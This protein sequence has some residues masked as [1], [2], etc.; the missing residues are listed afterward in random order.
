MN[1]SFY[2]NNIRCDI[3]HSFNYNNNTYIIY[4]DGSYDNNHKL[5]VLASKFVINNNE[6][7]LLPISDSEWEIVDKEWDKI[8]G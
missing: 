8:N 1:S 3:L 2:I 5:N 4:N 6:L 7:N